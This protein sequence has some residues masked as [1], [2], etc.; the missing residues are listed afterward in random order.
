M[1]KMF[2]LLAVAAMASCSKS[3][4]VERP[5]GDVEIMAKSNALS[6]T[7][8]APFDGPIS[9]TA[10]FTAKVFVSNTTADYK[11][12]LNTDTQMD[13][14]NN[15][16]DNKPIGFTTT[17]AYYPADGSTVYLC[18]AYPYTAGV[19]DFATGTNNLQANLDGK[20]DLM[21]A[22]EETSD[23]ASAQAGTYPTLTFEHLLTKLSV[24]VV[25]EDQAAI[26]AWGKITDMYLTKQNQ[27][28]LNSIVLVA[29]G[30]DVATA[31]PT[32]Q[33]NSAGKNLTSLACYEIAADGTYGDTAYAGT[34][35]TTTETAVAYSLVQPVIATEKHYTLVVKT[36]NH[37]A[38]YPVDVT[39]KQTG[40]TN[41]FTDSTRGY[42]FNVKLTFKA[43]EIKALATVTAWKDGGNTGVD[44]E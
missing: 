15:A 30:S 27:N 31:A 43:S 32:Y 6:V 14:V 35:L 21:I 16:S 12:L 4:L 37:T 20:T 29:A 11:T 24:S 7:T 26:D 40:D 23:K 9:S 44:I 34:T 19:W 41:V 5:A 22:K 17:K 2:L 10:P 39:L 1:K 28:D 38:E 25:A 13:F 36:E 18:G 33:A 8:K 42:A 3:E